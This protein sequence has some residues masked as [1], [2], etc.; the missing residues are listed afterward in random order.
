MLCGI[1]VPT[2]HISSRPN[3]IKH[4]INWRALYIHGKIDFQCN[5]KKNIPFDSIQ[6]D[7][8]LDILT[9]DF[10]CFAC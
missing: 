2:V 3:K 8:N 4:A 5:D 9:D 6:C 10:K 7:N 1:I